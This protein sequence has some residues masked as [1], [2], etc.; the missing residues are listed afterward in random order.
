[1]RIGAQQLDRA[2]GGAIGNKHDLQPVFR[3]VE[4]AGV[5]QLGGEESGA[6]AHC[7]EE[8]DRGRG[9]R[10]RGRRRGAT[11]GPQ[12]EQQ[13]VAGEEG[14][15]AGGGEGPEAEAQGGHGRELGPGWRL[16]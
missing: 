15:D 12:P 8:A 14:Q 4:G 10:R 6:V 2:I 16:N 3:V 13:R 9:I 7:D 1:M 5:G 11:Q